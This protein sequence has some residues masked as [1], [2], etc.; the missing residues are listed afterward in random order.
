MMEVIDLE[1]I[2]EHARSKM[3]LG[4][5]I[6]KLIIWII[7][8]SFLF[9][10]GWI[11]APSDLRKYLTHPYV[12]IGVYGYMIY[13]NV[14]YGFDFKKRL[15]VI[16]EINK[17]KRTSDYPLAYLKW[18]A[19]RF[20]NKVNMDEKRLDLLKVFSPFPLVVYLFGVFLENKLQTNIGIISFWLGNFSF[21]DVIM[22]VGVALFIIYV[23]IIR[24]A[25]LKYRGDL[26]T[27]SLFEQEIA[28]LEEQI[29]AKKEKE[30]L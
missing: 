20:K 27:Y 26:L 19:T 21:R 15:T 17:I 4:E 2:E 28:S 6:W 9:F 30:S 5:A 24:E 8:V 1:Q 22:F 14:Q 12:V 16:G 13:S 7:F 29:K 23:I 25:Y 11:L 18:Q 3:A 10:I